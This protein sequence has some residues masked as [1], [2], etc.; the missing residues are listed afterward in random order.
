MQVFQNYVISKF[1][2]ANAAAVGVIKTWI[3]INVD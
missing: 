2:V 1:A 3:M